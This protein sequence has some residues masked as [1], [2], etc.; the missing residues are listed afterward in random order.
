MPQHRLTRPDLAK[1]LDVGARDEGSTRSNHHDR[2]YAVIFFDLFQGVGNTSGTP[3]LS[4]FTGGFSIVMIATL[5]WVA[6]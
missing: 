3:G 4:A 6:R 2:Y 5:P 1:F